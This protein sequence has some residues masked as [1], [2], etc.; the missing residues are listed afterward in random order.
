MRSVRA[1]AALIALPILAVTLS[2]CGSAA[3]AP[4]GATTKRLQVVTTVAPITSITANVAGDRADIT[5]IVPEGTNSH[6]FEPPPSAAEAL[7]RADVVLV[8]GLKLEDPTLELARKVSRRGT[9]PLAS[10]A[11][12]LAENRDL[13]G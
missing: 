12:P 8:N 13:P 11:H 3:S 4:A 10:I 5:G 9:Q 1:T 6:T 7:G 2:A